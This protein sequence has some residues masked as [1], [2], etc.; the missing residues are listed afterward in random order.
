M[1]LR[2]TLVLGLICNYMV[3][4]VLGFLADGSLLA[5]LTVILFVHRLRLFFNK[6]SPKSVTVASGIFLNLIFLIL[7]LFLIRAGFYI[8]AFSIVGYGYLFLVVSLLSI[9][10]AFRR[11]TSVS[12]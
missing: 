10:P 11:K 1:D 5:I 7:G 6:E 3:L 8:S 2:N 9:L 4:A 12:M